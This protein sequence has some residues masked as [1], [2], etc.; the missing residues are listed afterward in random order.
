MEVA[1]EIAAFTCL[2]GRAGARR[3]N[4]VCGPDLIG[5]LFGRKGV[6]SDHADG[7]P[8]TEFTDALNQVVSEAIVVVD[9]QDH[10][11][12]VPTW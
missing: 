9:D 3:Y 1:D 6:I 5:G 4:Q 10:A 12:I 2:I 8:S 11:G 7:I